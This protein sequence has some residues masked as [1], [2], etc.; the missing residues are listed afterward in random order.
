VIVTR[1]IEEGGA[2]REQSWTVRYLA[3]REILEVHPCKMPETTEECPEPT[4]TIT[5]PPNTTT[6]TPGG[7]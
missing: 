2:E 4:T 1:F 5:E 6:T 3:R 7:G